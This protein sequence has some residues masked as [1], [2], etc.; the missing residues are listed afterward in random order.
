MW[1]SVSRQNE[2]VL[3][4]RRR[5]GSG[6]EEGA[7]YPEGGRTLE[8]GASSAILRGRLLNWKESVVKGERV[9]GYLD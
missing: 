6:D 2:V 4:G 7:D 1:L 8:E 5:R 3:R 9:K